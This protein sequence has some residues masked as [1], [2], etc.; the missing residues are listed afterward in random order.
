M[1]IYSEATRVKSY[2]VDN[3]GKLS[4]VQVFNFLQEAAF[5]HSVIDNFGQ[6]NLA[7]LGLVWMLSRMKVVFLEEAILGETIE[8]KSWVRSIKGTLSERDFILTS[9]GKVIVKATSLW[10]CLSIEPLKPTA[11]P[12]QIL[13]R[14]Y[15]H[16]ELDIDFRTAK[17]IPIQGEIDSFNYTIRTSDVDM[18]NHTNNVAYVRMVL[19]AN[20]SN[21]RITQVDINYLRQSFEGDELIINS[22]MENSSTKF[23]EVVNEKELVV[24]RLKTEWL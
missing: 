15:I 23:H 20:R 13:D 16:D 11:I 24:C 4:T 8:I 5:R 12:T 10:A 7:K 9:G 22:Q 1:K 18:V 6:L 21:K 2:H 17:I 3:K 19:D 14:M